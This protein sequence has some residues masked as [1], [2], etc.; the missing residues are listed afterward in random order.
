MN[1]ELLVSSKCYGLYT[2]QNEIVGFCAVVHQPHNYVKNMK[3]VH[4]LVILPDYQG[5]G[6]GIRFLNEIAERYKNDGFN[7]HIVT[8][9]KNM[10]WA[11]Y[12]S[13]KWKMTKKVDSIASKT[14]PNGIKGLNKSIKKNA[15]NGRFKYIG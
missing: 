4:R 3:R 11:L 8:S 5:M 13:E 15:I 9:A 6:L 12:R 14:S 1:T 7:F 2:E 10:I